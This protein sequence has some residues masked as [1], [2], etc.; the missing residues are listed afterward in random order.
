MNEQKPLSSMDISQQGDE[1]IAVTTSAS[2]T[3]N[4]SVDDVIRLREWGT[5]TVYKLSDRSCGPR[6]IG[7]SRGCTVRLVDPTAA[8]THAQIT[9]DG[10]QWWIRRCKPTYGLHQDGVPRER[11]TLTPGVEVGVGATTLIAESSRTVLLRGFCQ[12]LLGW[13]DD[14]RDA[15]DHAL[16]A[17][18]LG[19][20]R[21]TALIIA[22]EGDLAPIA[23]LFHRHMLGECAP[24]VVCS[25][26]RMNGRA[27]VRAPANL[28][29]GVEA[30]TAAAGG[31]LCLLSAYLPRDVDQVIARTCHPSSSVQLVL[32]M[33]S[34]HRRLGLTGSMP[35]QVPPLQIRRLELPRI[36]G[37]YAQEAI[38]M[39]GESSSAFTDDDR[40]WV[41]AHASQTHQQIE[42]A[43]RRLVARRTSAS[44]EQAAARLEMAGVSLSRWFA[45]RP[46][47]GEAQGIPVSMLPPRQARSRVRTA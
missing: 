23:H 40:R 17:M 38:E 42:K 27:S 16:R 13:G 35:I 43:T 25:T 9:F 36:I 30:F 15:V 14:R 45:R 28:V 44:L 32:G 2:T 8:P 22:G 1:P 26:R 10:G 37:E 7:T 5:D 18:R 29:W 47:P 46:S 6:F 41:I 4:P 3:D 34:Q 11:F 20:A 31:S 24:F 33:P 19:M 12:R 21:R 39:L